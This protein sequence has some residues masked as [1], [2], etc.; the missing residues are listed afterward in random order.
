MKVFHGLGNLKFRNVVAVSGAMLATWYILQS[1][2]QDSVEVND[3][4]SDRLK[5]LDAEISANTSA[6]IW[7]DRGMSIK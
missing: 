2:S 3:F 6:R 1:S 7:N 4:D 5:A